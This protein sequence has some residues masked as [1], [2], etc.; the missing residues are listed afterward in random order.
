[1]QNFSIWTTHSL[2]RVRKNRKPEDRKN[3]SLCGAKGEYESFQIVI[4][5]GSEPLTVENIIFSDFAR[6]SGEKLCDNIDIYREHYISFDRNSHHKGVEGVLEQELVGSVPD[7][8]IPALDPTTRKPL[9]CSARFYAF[10]HNMP[11]NDVQPYFID[12]KIPRGAKGGIYKSEYTVVTDKG[13]FKGEVTLEIWE[14]ELPIEQ[15]QKSFFGSW[16]EASSLKTEEAARHRIFIKASSKEEQEMLYEKYGYNTSH[17]GFW[18]GADIERPNMNPA[19][20]VE[21]VKEKLEKYSDKTERFAYTADEIGFRKDLYPEII[22][23]GQ[24]L[25]KA[26]AKQLIVMPPVN[27]LLDDGLGT[28]QS[29]VDIWVVLPKQYYEYK[30]NIDKAVAKGDSL[31]TYNCLIQDNYSPKWLMDF[32]VLCY[33]LQPGFI[34]YSLK[35]EGFL[36]WLIDGYAKLEDPWGD[37]TVKPDKY[38]DTWVRDGMLFYPG[39][40]VGLDNSF[41]PSLRA[42]AVRDGFEDYELCHKISCM[43]KGAL[44]EHYSNIIGKDF[45]S[46][47]DDPEVLLLNRQ[48]LGKAFCVGSKNED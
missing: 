35:A 37:I 3:F 14:I 48:K 27:E 31:W 40:D 42:K 10:P 19:P 33:R 13:D 9:G 11:E 20:E 38:G 34:N 43:G 22:K 30:R 28:G 29:A 46:W 41:V 1:M 39:E 17:I 5:S 45:K 21:A 18:S 6:D 26:G 25:H 23:Y 15:V 2:D 4:N 36:Y 7:A 12:V 24:A 44:A 8:L 32:S 16:T 47:T